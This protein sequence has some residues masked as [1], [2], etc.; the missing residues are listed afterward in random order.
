M[1]SRGMSLL[2]TGII[3]ADIIGAIRESCRKNWN[4]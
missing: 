3:K 1:N 4:L 2:A